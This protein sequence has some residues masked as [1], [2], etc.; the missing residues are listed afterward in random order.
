MLHYIIS[1]IVYTLA[2]AGVLILGFVVYKKSTDFTYK[3][4]TL[5]KV[6][7]TMRLPDRKTLY[8]INCNEERFLIASCADK[9]S[10]ISKLTD[11]APDAPL[12]EHVE[13]RSAE[14]N[15][16]ILKSLIKEMSDINKQTRST[17]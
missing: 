14:V 17:F 1:F 9:I 15:D 5:I 11:K 6:E 13:D 2:M 10:L 12:T 4:S 16:K 7:D 8:I 3:K